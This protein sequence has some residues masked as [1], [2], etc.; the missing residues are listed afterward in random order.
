MPRA[1]A[2]VNARAEAAA[3]SIKNQPHYGASYPWHRLCAAQVSAL[4]AVGRLQQDDRNVLGVT[5]HR[6]RMWRKQADS[7]PLLG[8]RTYLARTGVGGLTQR[9]RWKIIPY[10]LR[11]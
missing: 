3:A 2:S 9:P 8:S 5:C 6:S 1:P 4:H 7:S 10:G 11:A